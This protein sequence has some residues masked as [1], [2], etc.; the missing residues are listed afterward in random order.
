M[1]ALPRAGEQRVGSA[2]L[3]SSR[4]SRRICSRPFSVA[5]CCCVSPPLERS[6]VRHVAASAAN[7]SATTNPTVSA[8]TSFFTEHATQI[9]LVVGAAIILAALIKVINKGSRKY[10]GNVGDE[11]DA[12]T[13]EGILEH[14][15][16]E[17]IHLGYYTEEERQPGFFAWGK[18]D[19]KEAKY[20]F[21]DE[22]LKWS[23]AEAPTTVLD[24]GCGFGGTSRRLAAK[25]PQATVQGITLSP[26]QVKRGT[27]L[28]VERGLDNVN[29]QVMDALAM[30][31][32]DNSFDLVWACESGEHMPDKK[33]Y[34]EEMVRV[35]KPGG[36]LV[37]ACWCQREEGDKPFTQKDKND[38]K[39]LYE[40]WAHPFFISKEEFVR[41]MDGTG[42]V[43]G[44][45]CEDW[46]EQT[47]PS[48][49]QSIWVGVESPWYVIFKLNPF[50]WWKV[51]REIVTL[52]RMHK[53][54]KSGLMEYGM[55]K[56]KKAVKAPSGA[57]AGKVL[58]SDSA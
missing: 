16:G 23:G 46:C 25:Y 41:L 47:L 26:E 44:S 43:E 8:F 49:R 13:Q 56:A 18:K 53:A 1:Q 42:Q 55:M 34:V 14:Y 54:F 3:A 27:E 51:I 45:S 9:G 11:Y 15:W 4:T 52:E 48:W 36:T 22:M 10:D 17:H 29:F 35:L 7:A 38:L 21:I 2:R 33:K 50:I 58:S 39:F 57:S 30:E 32:P 40:E 6:S 31:W 20:D 12:W 28:A 5:Q 24:V 19:F 37:I